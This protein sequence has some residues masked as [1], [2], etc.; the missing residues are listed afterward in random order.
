MTAFEKFMLFLESEMETPL[1]YGAFHIVA[2]ILCA[3]L[4]AFLIWKCKN[5][6]DKTMRWIIGVSW[7][8]IVVLELYKQL[9]FS[10]NEDDL[11]WEYN[12]FYFPFQFCSTPLYVLPFV[13]F[14]KDG[15]IRDAMIAYTMTYSLFAGLCVMAYPGDVF[16]ST[17]GINYQTM[18]HHGSQVTLGIFLAVH[19]RKKYSLNFFLSAGIVFLGMLILAL[20]FNTIG[21]KILP[22][23]GFNMFYIGPNEPCTLPL[24]SMIY[25]L[26]PWVVFFVIYALG[27]SLV[28]ALIA[29]IAYSIYKGPKKKA[30]TVEQNE[31]Y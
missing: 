14:M 15:K 18:I 3:G 29:W 13:A 10:F 16:I 24:L 28:G 5:C 12:W 17:I 25:P 26:V 8:I 4:T 23:V 20:G 7:V 6:E 19:Q 1:C 22:D 9:V 27:F 31:N 30:K 11:T 21:N 2:L